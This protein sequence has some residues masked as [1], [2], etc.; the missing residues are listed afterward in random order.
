MSDAADD[1]V[2]LDEY[3]YDNNDGKDDHKEDNLDKDK[4]NKNLIVKKICKCVSH[5]ICF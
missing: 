4:D 3:D 2:D 1:N 5:L